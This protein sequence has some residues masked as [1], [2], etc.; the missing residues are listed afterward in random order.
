LNLL[1]STCIIDADDAKLAYF[2]GPVSVQTS[3]IPA[4]IGE[5]PEGVIESVDRLTQALGHIQFQDVMRQR[6]QHVQEA[7]VEMRDHM[8]SMSE[9]A[10]DFV[11]EGNFDRTFKEML[12]AHKDGYRMASQTVTHLNV[13]GGENNLDHSRPKIELF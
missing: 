2:E 8:R 11:W 5:Y 12:E 10:F 4:T 9:R 3:R 13:A 7:L 1:T 6:M